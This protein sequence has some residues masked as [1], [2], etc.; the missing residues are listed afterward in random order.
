MAAKHYGTFSVL[1]YSEEKSTWSFNVGAITA[2]SIAGFL[3]AFGNLRTSLTNIITGTVQKEKWVGDDTVLS[4]VPP[5]DSNSQIELKFLL[6]YEADTTKKIFHSEIPSPDTSKLIPGTDE[7]DLTDVD[8]ADF[9][10]DFEAIAR[11]PDSDTETVTVLGMHLV[12]RNN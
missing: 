1:D 3:T 8:V 6:S 5:V 2:V 7:V 11:S 12:G 10:T 4:N 9:I